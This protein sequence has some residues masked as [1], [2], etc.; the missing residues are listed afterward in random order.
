MNY[1]L[2]IHFYLGLLSGNNKAKRMEIEGLLFDYLHNN[3]CS[4]SRYRKYKTASAEFAVYY[5]EIDVLFSFFSTQFAQIID[6]T[7]DTIRKQTLEL[8]QPTSNLNLFYLTPAYQEPK[9]VSLNDAVKGKRAT[10]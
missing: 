5:K 8:N 2:K 9:V 7:K 4:V 3:G 6:Q 1:Y 10:A